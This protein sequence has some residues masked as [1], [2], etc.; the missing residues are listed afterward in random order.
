MP[1]INEELNEIVSKLGGTPKGNTKVTD[2]LEEIIA[3]LSSGGGGG[4]EGLY[5]I[6]VTQNPDTG[7]FTT[8]CSF[9]DLFANANKVALVTI[10][11]VDFVTPSIGLIYADESYAQVDFFVPS[12]GLDGVTWNGGYIYTSPEDPTE[13]EISNLWLKSTNNVRIDFSKMKPVRIDKTFEELKKYI[14][15]QVTVTLGNYADGND[16]ACYGFCMGNASYVNVFYFTVIDD[17]GPLMLNGMITADEDNVTYPAP[18]MTQI[19]SG[20]GDTDSFLVKDYDTSYP[21][22]VSDRM[23]V[24]SSH[25]VTLLGNIGSF[26]IYETQYIQ[27]DFLS[28]FDLDDIIIDLDSG[29]YDRTILDLKYSNTSSGTYQG[30]KGDFIVNCNSQIETTKRQFRS[31]KYVKVK[32]LSSTAGLTSI[33]PIQVIALKKRTNIYDKGTQPSGE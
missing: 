14:G 18:K 27:T 5:K 33:N 29:S 23:G 11:M 17:D 25:N 20:G 28:K 8:D 19:G 26:Y 9:A 13:V 30:S 24:G 16:I 21:Y 32:F 7:E 12:S 4:G 10:R 15:S 2:T 1:R 31:N 22:M 3:L 6:T